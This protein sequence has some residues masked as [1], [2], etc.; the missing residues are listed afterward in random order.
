MVRKE[1]LIQKTKIEWTLNP[2]GTPGFTWNPIPNWDGYFACREGF[3]GTTKR[4]EFRTM[5]SIKAHDGHL[6]VFLYSNGVMK[7]QWVHRLILLTFS[8]QPPEGQE[9]RHLNGNPSDNRIENLAWGTRQENQLDR[10]IHGTSNRGERSW[11]HKLTAI[12]VLAIRQRIESCRL[13]AK[14]YGVSHTT[15]LY[16]R[17]G[18]HWR[19]L[20]NAQQ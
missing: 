14:E 11:S 1:N 10:I 9:S 6:Y 7:K 4:G 17:N 12:D 3:I 8:G 15:I 13:L 18:H 5:S 19:E 20:C 16:A 2:D